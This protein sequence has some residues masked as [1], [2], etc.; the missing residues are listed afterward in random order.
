MTREEFRQ[1]F[2]AARKARMSSK[3]HANG[4]CY[5]LRAGGVARIL[6]NCAYDRQQRE[7]VAMALNHAGDARR[8]LRLPRACYGLV[9][10]AREWRVSGIAG[11]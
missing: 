3:I 8:R 1:A 6:P 10:L 4:A 5:A 9:S 7:A 2:G 11:I